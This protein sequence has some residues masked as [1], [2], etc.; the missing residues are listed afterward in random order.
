MSAG[1]TGYQTVSTRCPHCGGSAIVTGLTLNQ[2]VEVGP[3]GLRYK[4]AAIFTGT[5]TLHADLCQS[6]GSIVR[7]FVK[8]VN[9]RW[10]QK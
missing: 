8:E 1:E 10:I 2:G 6:C 3:F 9:R 5:E 7:F 4:A